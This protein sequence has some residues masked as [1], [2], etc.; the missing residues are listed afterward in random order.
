MTLEDLREHGVLLP[1]EEWGQHSLETTAR[2]WVLG[3]GLLLA[4]ASLVL[5]LVGAGGLL[6]WVGVAAFLV[7]FFVITWLLDRAVLR[8]RARVRRERREARESATE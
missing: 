2:E 7:L 5:A 8:Q 1:E 6:T 3:V 4:A